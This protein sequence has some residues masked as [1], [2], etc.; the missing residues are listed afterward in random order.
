MI[1]KGIF[2]R[3][4]LLVNKSARYNFISASMATHE[5]TSRPVIASDNPTEAPAW[6]RELLELLKRPLIEIRRGL[7][8]GYDPP[9][10]NSSVI[11]LTAPSGKFVDI[12]FPLSP[13]SRRSPMPDPYEI[14]GYAT[15][16]L[17]TPTILPG[18]G[19]CPPYECAALMTWEHPIDSSR[20][21]GKA[22]AMMYLLANRDVMEV[23]TMEFGG[24]LQLFTEYWVGPKEGAKTLPCIV[25]E[26]KTKAEDSN[27]SR[28]MAIRV[29]DY[30]QG[31]VQDEQ[32]FRLERW[33]LNGDQWVKDQRSNTL[34]LEENILP[35]E[36]MISQGGKL[37][38]CHAVDGRNWQI[39]ELLEDA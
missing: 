10:E 33:E 2:K 22:S 28:G 3:F 20:G 7:S 9:S 30:C 6:T 39:T 34:N 5:T 23:G 21:F 8:F 24:K 36:W 27:G 13:T 14:N 4:E 17:S 18:T 19:D 32:I 29:G 25:M 38:D 12:R 26:L 31:I 1:R 11:A 15:A 35:C 37:G 16:G